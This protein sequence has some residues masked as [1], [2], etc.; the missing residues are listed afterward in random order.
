M[1]RE[2]TGRAEKQKGKEEGETQETTRQGRN[3][4][5][6]EEVCVCVMDRVDEISA[7]AHLVC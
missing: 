4:N 3:E 7:A 6:I 2:I 5:L 1:R